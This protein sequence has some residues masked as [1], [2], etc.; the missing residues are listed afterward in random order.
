[1]D[2]GSCRQSPHGLKVPGMSGC[3]P[4]GGVILPW[5]LQHPHPGT[6]SMGQQP[7]PTY[8]YYL[9]SHLG[10]STPIAACR[11]PA[12]DSALGGS[13]GVG[14]GQ[15][16]ASVRGRDTDIGHRYQGTSMDTGGKRVHSQ[17]HVYPQAWE[18][19]FM[20]PLAQVSNPPFVP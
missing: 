16:W 5:Y 15:G 18:F 20:L 4:H 10:G 3:W 14:L 9:W 7:L 6:V 2:L 11:T 13:A 1:M 12:W 19:L 17:G 8:C